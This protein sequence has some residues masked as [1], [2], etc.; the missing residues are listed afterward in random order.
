MSDRSLARGASREKEV[1][2]RGALGAGKWRLIRQFLT[3]NLLLSVL[4]GSVGLALGYAMV[5][6]LK[7]LF[8]SDDAA[9]VWLNGHEWAKRQAVRAG[10]EFAALSNGFAACDQPERLRAVCDSFGPHHVQA[11]FDRWITQFPTPLSAED[12]AAGYWWELS[13]RQVEISRT[14]VLDD[15]RRARSFFEALVA[16]NIGIGRPEEVSLVFARQLRRPTRHPYQTRIFS[17]GTEVRIDFRYKHSRVKQYLKGGRA[18]RIETVINKPA[19]LDVAARLHNL[20]Q[21]TDKARQVNHAHNTQ[22]SRHRLHPNRPPHA[23]NINPSQRHDFCRPSGAT[24]VS[25]TSLETGGPF[26]AVFATCAVESCA[27]LS[28]GPARA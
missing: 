11:F 9:K 13:M 3:E 19:D 27:R 16:D 21:L 6:G 2:I 4:G 26:G 24:P 5:A 15:P 1:A 10:I 28:P 25:G 20:P 18:L 8:G 17:T 22:S 23:R 14:L 7:L 12:R